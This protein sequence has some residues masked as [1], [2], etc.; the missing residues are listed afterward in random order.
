MQFKQ[1]YALNSLLPTRLVPVSIDLNGL[2]HFAFGFTSVLCVETI[3]LLP[4]FN[5]LFSTDGEVTQDQDVILL[6]TYHAYY[7]AR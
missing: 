3:S 7:V 5:S 4:F 2:H 6:L 1:F